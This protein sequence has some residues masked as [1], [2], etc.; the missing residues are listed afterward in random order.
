MERRR[1]VGAPPESFGATT[2]ISLPVSSQAAKPIS[3]T[4]MITVANGTYCCAE[5]IS[6]AIS[7]PKIPNTVRNPAD[8]T[9][10]AAPAR[11]SATGR[12]VIWLPPAMTK[13]R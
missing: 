11:A 8:M 5:A 9:S 2:A 12:D 7:R 1:A 10:V 3:N 4:P 13:S 6:G